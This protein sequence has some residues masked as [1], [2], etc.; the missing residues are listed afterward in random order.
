M[1]FWPEPNNLSSPLIR[2]LLSLSTIKND[3]RF[4]AASLPKYYRQ[5]QKPRT[6]GQKAYGNSASSA[7]LDAATYEQGNQLMNLLSEGKDN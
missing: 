1:N 3:C 4:S 5:K 7:N 6:I 2:T